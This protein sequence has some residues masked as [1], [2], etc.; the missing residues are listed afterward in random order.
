MAEED[1]YELVCVVRRLLYT[2]A[3]SDESQRKRIFKGKCSITNRVCKL[4]INSC[5]CENQV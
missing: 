5:S 4:V 3:P 2:P 1:G